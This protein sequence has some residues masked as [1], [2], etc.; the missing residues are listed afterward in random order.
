MET[1]FTII[2]YVSPLQLKELQ[3]EANRERLRSSFTASSNSFHMLP[4]H[5]A[6]SRRSFDTS[7]KYDTSW[8][9]NPKPEKGDMGQLTTLIAPFPLG[10]PAPSRRLGMSDKQSKDTPMPK[11]ILDK[12][13]KAFD[14][15]AGQS[16]DPKFKFSTDTSAAS[17]QSPKIQLYQVPL[18][19]SP[20][21]QLL[22]SLQ[23]FAI[24]VKT[25]PPPPPP[26]RGEPA[27]LIS[28]RQ[29]FDE[30][31]NELQLSMKTGIRP[32]SAISRGQRIPKSQQIQQVQQSLP[33][34]PTSQPAKESSTKPTREIPAPQRPHSAMPKMQADSQKPH[35][36]ASASPSVKA[37]Q[38]SSQNSPAKTFE[39]RTKVSKVS[40]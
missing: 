36:P 16:L 3:Y 12:L 33:S 24:P 29:V 5:F 37:K 11:L 22:E 38:S 13:E 27:P 9:T 30:A 21:A 10:Q 23:I 34:A 7:T 1:P 39:P 4:D 40:D 15:H 35:R 8:F 14:Q 26:K 32:A 20:K 25:P 6:L 19:P 18:P 28:N 31:S 17:I 2:S